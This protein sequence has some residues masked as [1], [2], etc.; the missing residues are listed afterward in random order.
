MFDCALIVH[1]TYIRWKGSV[2]QEVKCIMVAYMRLKTVVKCPRRH[3]AP[4]LFHFE[5]RRFLLVFMCRHTRVD[6][7]NSPCLI[8]FSSLHDTALVCKHLILSLKRLARVRVYQLHYGSVM[9]TRILCAG[10]TVYA[11]QPNWIDLGKQEF[12]R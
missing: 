3:F 5:F 1:G 11:W 9:H 12:S 6:S 2:T 8:I 10:G 4:L 7:S